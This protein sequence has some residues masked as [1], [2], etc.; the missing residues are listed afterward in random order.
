MKRDQG[1]TGRASS[2]PAGLACGAALS[3]AVTIAVSALL[4]RLVDTQRLEWEKI[5]YGILVL[6]PTASFLGAMLSY[7]KIR[8]QR[9]AVCMASGGIYMGMLLAMTA[10]FFGGQYASVGISCALVLGGSLAA[11]LLGLRS[12]KGSRA[13]KIKISP[14]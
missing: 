3:M 7:H 1:K 9:M 13:R 4:A 11:G 5:G 14:R 6:L 8:R 2:T 10:L 12:E